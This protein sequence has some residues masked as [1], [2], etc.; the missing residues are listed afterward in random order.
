MADGLTYEEAAA[1]LG[2]HFSNVAKLI[3]KGDLT[4]TGKRGASLNRRQVEALAERRAAERAARAAWPGQLKGQIGDVAMLP[5]EVRL[6][7]ARAVVAWPSSASRT[8]TSVTELP[9]D[10]RQDLASGSDAPVSSILI[11][12]LS[13]D[14]LVVTLGAEFSR[15]ALLVTDAFSALG[16]PDSDFLYDPDHFFGQARGRLLPS[17]DFA[18]EVLV[19]GSWSVAPSAARWTAWVPLMAAALV[20]YP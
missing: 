5:A 11:S 10:Q 3:R 15:A 17:A 12:F 4:S 16:L 19:S 18:A 9:R 14:F 20:S 8:A 6:R 1:I 2:C 13:S 7:D